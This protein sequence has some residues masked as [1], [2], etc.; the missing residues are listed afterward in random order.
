MQKS[1]QHCGQKIAIVGTTGSGKTTLARKIA[2]QLQVIH[3]ELDA[4]HWEK[5]WT[6]AAD[7]VFR[8][9]VTQAL[10]G[11]RWVVD[12]NY[13]QVRDII[14]SQADTILFLDYSFW[15][16]MGR[17]LRRTLRRSW[18]QEEL[19]NG[20]REDFKLSF[21]S[22]DSIILWMLR[23]HHQ[24]RKKYPLLFQQPKYSHL[25][26]VHLKF[27]QMTDEWLRNCKH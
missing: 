21:F 10:S 18:L 23:T 26:V 20:N 12:G 9:R 4:L 3:I 15:L 13:S 1:S 22:Q 19:W 25:S 16:V 24:N 11:D 17:L 6:V 27:P 7:E 2:Q 8:E 5:N 14:W